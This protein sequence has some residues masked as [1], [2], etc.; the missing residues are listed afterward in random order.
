MATNEGGGNTKK[1][2]E[3][4]G[5]ITVIRVDIKKG[6]GGDRRDDDRFGLGLGSEERESSGG[7]GQDN[8]LQHEV[9]STMNILSRR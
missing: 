5:R 2:K 3:D 9:P 4:E 6:G 1:E 8:T 7:N